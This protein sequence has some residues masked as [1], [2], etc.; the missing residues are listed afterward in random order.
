MPTAPKLLENM[1]KNMTNEEIAI[2]K[3]AEVGVLPD[4]GD[5]DLDR[6]KFLT[7]AARKYW[8]RIL[9]RMVGLSILDDLDSEML[10]GYCLML[11]RRDS[12]EKELRG[13]SKQIATVEDAADLLDAQKDLRSKLLSLER[14]LL[15]YA[16]KLGLTPTGRVRL[17]QQ[18]AKQAAQADP[19]EDLAETE[20]E[21]SGYA[22]ELADTSEKQ[23]QTLQD[24]N[25]NMTAGFN[26]A[27]SMNN[28][29][30]KGMAANIIAGISVNEELATATDAFIRGQSA[31][32]TGH[33]TGLQRVPYDNYPALLHEGE[34]V[35]TAQEAR[36]YN[37]KTWVPVAS[38]WG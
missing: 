11:A 2:R 6:P 14:N 36:S 24:I 22:K 23:Y 17:A 8:D 28:I 12:W 34:R 9:E 13:L 20:Y 15:A 10:A 25:S 26:K 29:M 30:S 31:K 33:A 7:G 4:R 21:A 3:E 18:R 16:E 19:D 5:V 35:L 38:V 27:Y 1:T 37:R 32:Y